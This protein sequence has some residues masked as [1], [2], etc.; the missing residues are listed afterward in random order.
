MD[1]ELSLAI[2]PN[3]GITYPASNNAPPSFTVSDSIRRPPIIFGKVGVSHINVETV[4]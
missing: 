4:G 2:L 3:I 1:L